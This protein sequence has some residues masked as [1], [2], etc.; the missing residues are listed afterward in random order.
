MPASLEDLLQ[1]EHVS[2]QLPALAE[3]RFHIRSFLS[4][5]EQKAESLGI[6]AQQYQ[7]LQVIASAAPQ[8]CS[9]SHLAARLLLRHNSAVELV[10]RGTRSG[11]VRRTADAA[12]LRR[13]MLQIT[14][15]GRTV[16]SQLV[17]EHLSYLKQ[18]GRA[19]IE[20]LERITAVP[21]LKGLHT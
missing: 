13:S 19:M 20:A 12:D 4:F 10:D 21:S 6:T 16:L 3:F 7:M 11:L 18:D 5:S 8:G 2:A 17:G 9:I 15:H 14:E 1:D